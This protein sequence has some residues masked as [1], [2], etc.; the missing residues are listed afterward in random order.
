[1]MSE[2]YNIVGVHIKDYTPAYKMT[3]VGNDTFFGVF[4]LTEDATI[5][6]RDPDILRRMANGMNDLADQMD[7][8]AAMNEELRREDVRY[9]CHG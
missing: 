5:Y 3:A 8:G 4:P 2:N 7:Y 9:D 1:M 6:V